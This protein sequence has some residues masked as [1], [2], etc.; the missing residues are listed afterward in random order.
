MLWTVVAVRVLVNPFSNVLQKLLA[1]RGLSAVAIIGGT[2]A[3]LTLVSGPLLALE[4]PPANWPFWSSMMLTA[5]LAVAGNVLIVKAV[6]MSDLSI[7]GPINSYKPVVSLLPG[8]IF[9]GELPTQSAVAGIALI[10]VGSYVIAGTAAGN[11]S[12]RYGLRLC[13]DRGVQFRLAALVFSATEAVFLKRSVLASSVLPT[14]AVWSILGWV[15]LM[16]WLAGRNWRAAR[17]MA[18]PVAGVNRWHIAANYLSLAITTGLMQFCTIVVLAGF[19][20]GASLA[21]FQLS[22]LVSVLLGWRVFHEPAVGRRLAGA[23]LMTA[24]AALIVAAR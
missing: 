23:S 4:P 21:L 2:H 3:L 14:F 8:M 24:G 17:S 6:D 1:R 22:T 15:A 12:S 5:L 10:L 9:L 13:A 11:N 16:P 18:E 7:L 19:P 20:V